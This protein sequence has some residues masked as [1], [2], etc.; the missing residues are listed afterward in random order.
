MNVTYFRSRRPGPEVKIEDA[1]VQQIPDLFLSDRRPAWMAGSLPLGASM[2]DLVIVSCDPQI[3]ILANFEMPDAYILSYLRSV[4]RARIDTISER[5]GSPKEKILRCLNELVEA[6]A[7]LAHSNTYSLSPNC[8]DILPE[9]ITV[10]AKVKNW[11]SAVEQAVRNRIFAHKSFVALLTKVA[12]RVRTEP[13]FSRFGIGLLSV[14]DDCVKVV[15]RARH[16]QPRVWAYYYQL[17]FHA[18]SHFSELE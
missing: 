11:K 14:N 9:I 7:V 2:P 5:I 13:I 10:E 12:E 4:G 1:I 15:R 6:N 18:A 3:S 17:A 16:H 8:R